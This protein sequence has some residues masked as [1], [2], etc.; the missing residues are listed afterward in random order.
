MKKNIE[1]ALWSSSDQYNIWVNLICV[2]GVLFFFNLDSVL[3]KH[4]DEIGLWK[5][6]LDPLPLTKIHESQFLI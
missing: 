4:L 6:L 2:F 5:V 1:K 3:K